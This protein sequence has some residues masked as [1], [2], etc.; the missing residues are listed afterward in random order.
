MVE[1]SMCDDGVT[2]DSEQEAVG[3]TKCI[4]IIEKRQRGIT[5]ATITKT[6]RLTCN[7]G[8]EEAVE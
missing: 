6:Q 3:D 5:A 1:K 7:N 8:K 2:T 4:L